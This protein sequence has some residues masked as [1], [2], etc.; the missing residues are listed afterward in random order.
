M[1]CSTFNMG[2]AVDGGCRLDA[3]AVAPPA[4]C[5]LPIRQRQRQSIELSDGGDEESVQKKVTKKHLNVNILVD[6]RYQTY[7]D[8]SFLQNKPAIL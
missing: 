6:D 3:A 5:E 8:Q 4:E 2:S 7:H 1:N